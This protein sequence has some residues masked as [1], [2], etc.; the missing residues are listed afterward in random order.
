MNMKTRKRNYLLMGALT[1]VVSALAFSG[2]LGA[3]TQALAA[4]ADESPVAVRNLVPPGTAMDPLPETTCTVAGDVRTCELWAVAGTIDLPGAGAVPIWGFTDEEAGAAQLPG[5]TLIAYQGETLEVIVHNNLPGSQN[6][7]L[8][9]PGLEGIFPDLVGV[10]FEGAAT[11]S[12]PLE[13]PGTF[14][15][16]AGLTENG[17]RQ[18]AM[19]LY[20]GLIVRP[21]EHM[22]WAYDAVVTQFNDEYLLILSEIDP[23]F[24]ADPYEFRLYNFSPT[25]RLIN[26]KPYPGAEFLSSN[27]GSKV[28]LRY[29]NAGLEHYSLGLLGVG[30][31]ILAVDGELLPFTY[32]AVAETIGSGHSMDALVQIPV[33]ALEDSLYIL[34]DSSLLLH[35]AS[36]RLAGSNRLAFGGMLTYIHA[37]I[38]EPGGPAGPIARDVLMDPDPTTGAEGV[39]LTAAFD[40]TLCGDGVDVVEARYF[41]DSLGGEGTLLDVTAGQIVN[42]NHAFTPGLLETWPGGDHAVYVRAKDS[43]DNWGPPGSYVLNLDKLGPL[44]TGLALKPNPT[45]GQ[46]AVALQATGDD[47]ETGR[48]DVT[49]AEFTLNGG[50]P[51]PMT[52]NREAPVVSLTASI[53]ASDIAGLPEGAQ[54][55]AVRSQDSLGNWGDPQS[56]DLIIDQTGPSAENISLTPNHI[57]FSQPLEYTSVRLKATITDPLSNGVQSNLV[58]AEAFIN[59]ESQDGSGF[60]LFA[61]DGLFDSPVEEIYYEIPALTFARLVGDTHTILIHGK[62]IAGN[63]GAVGSAQI[64][65]EHPIQD[66]LG[67]VIAGLTVSPSPSAGA[68]NVLLQA[69]A[70]DYVSLIAGAE[71]FVGADPGPGNGYAIPAADGDFDDLHEDLEAAIYASTWPNGSYTLW[72]RAR[73]A[74]NNWGSPVSVQLVI[75]GNQDATIMTDDFTIAGFEGWTPAG[76]VALTVEANIAPPAGA[77]GPA[78]ASDDYG[79]SATLEGNLPAYLSQVYPVGESSYIASFYFQPNGVSLDGE[80]HEIFVGWDGPMSLFGIEVED[81]TAGGNTSS[82]EI[83]AWVRTSGGVIF[84]DWHDLSDEPHKLEISWKSAPDATFKF[85]IDGALI[86]ELTGLNTSPFTLHEVWLGASTGMSEFASGVEYYDGYQAVRLVEEEPPPP[87]PTP[88]TP[89]PPTPTP[90]TPTPP[91]PT[92]PTTDE[93]T[94]LYLPIISHER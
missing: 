70:M 66:L 9:F 87:T 23:A 86:A 14:L 59:E 58:T 55:V 57:D 69:V 90:P 60:A 52:L 79:V 75:T 72:V 51:R 38:G 91:T 11:Y 68:S 81:E 28:L 12:F 22:D 41:V 48:S 93:T 92:P 74:A 36:Q 83:R 61:K 6:L 2:M 49:A 45:N 25:Y 1:L 30:Q 62:D 10:A 34:H 15:Y 88:P 53:P 63:W 16:E 13:Q 80:E 84:T 26:G 24:N 31:T 47:H 32:G 50:E 37:G 65:I 71:W 18:V 46:T 40:C 29:I 39:T 73:D 82:Y 42:V 77:Q 64:T 89:T 78:S 85:S 20:G 17:A 67:P 35:N 5:P 56:I 33:E 94:I 43:S 21:S 8:V 3:K 76:N 7:S 4:S 54:A 44:T 27:A 19:G